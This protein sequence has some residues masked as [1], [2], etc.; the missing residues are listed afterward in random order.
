MRKLKPSKKLQSSKNSSMKI[1]ACYMVKNEEKNL[2]RSINSLKS[3]VDEIIVI[4]T[5][6]TDKTIEIA[7]SFGAKVLTTQWQDD[8][9]TPRNMAIDAA[10]G[11]WIIFLDADEYFVSAKNVR[12]TIEKLSNKESILIP[13]INIDEENGGNVI[14]RDWCLR[15]FKNVDH[16]RYRGLIH[17][18]V[19]NIKTGDLA[20]VFGSED[21]AIYHTGYGKQLIESKLR[22]NLALIEKEINLTGHKPQHDINLA[23]CYMGLGDYEKTIIY[24]KKALS[25]NVQELTGRGRTYR[26]LINAMR[27]LKYPDEEIVAVIDKAIKKLPNL[28][29]FYAERAINLCDLNRLDEAYD[30]FKKSLAVWRKMSND[31]HEDS[32]FPRIMYIVYAQLAELDA[33]KGDFKS[34]YKNI[35]EAIKLAPNK[36]IYKQRIIYFKSLEHSK[37]QV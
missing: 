13:R 8:F 15:I 1:S 25:S 16:L 32:Y 26:N 5:G 23:D 21:L 17:E 7:E 29:E 12:S 11:D 9:S 6:S 28:P 27:N 14:G 18:N 34:A 37:K 2:P 4:D 33:I 31:T 3:Q 24:A 30:S 22:R 35:D 19:A 36:E 10:T 20:Y